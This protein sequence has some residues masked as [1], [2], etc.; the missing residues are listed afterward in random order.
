MLRAFA[1]SLAWSLALA[2]AAAVMT[3][4]RGQAITG[5]ALAVI[6]VFAVAGLV[7]AL[8]AWV[9]AT[10]LTWR[11]RH[12][13]ARFAAMFACLVLG[14]AGT[15][16]LQLY[17]QIN[18]YYS[19]WHEGG[20]TVQSLF[21]FLFTSASAAYVLGVVGTRLLLPWVLPFAF[22]AAYAFAVAAPS[23]SALTACHPRARNPWSRRS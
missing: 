16:V 23:R 5:R 7:G 12:R 19:R 2:A 21:E 6:V 1:V 10:L 9:A 3:V 13:S 20:L 18:L 4:G 14:T 8:V 15:A 11:C 17:W 22:L